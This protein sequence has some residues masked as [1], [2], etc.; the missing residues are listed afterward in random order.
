MGRWAFS[1]ILWRET[2][3]AMERLWGIGEEER[4][5]DYA[6]QVARFI[7]SLDHRITSKTWFLS[8]TDGGMM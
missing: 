7:T 4:V 6:Q 3:Y 2:G 5:P 1:H 8:L